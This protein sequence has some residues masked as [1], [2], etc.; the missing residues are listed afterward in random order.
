MSAEKTM[1]DLIKEE[2]LESIGIGKIGDIFGGKG[3]TKS[4]KIKD[5]LDGLKK[6]L[7]LLEKD[8]NGLCFVN[9]V[10]FDMK[11]GHRNDTDGYAKAMTECDRM[12]GKIVDNL[13]EDDLLIITADHGCDPATQSTD[14]SREYVPMLIYGKRLKKG[15]DLKTIEGFYNIGATILD[16]LE[17]CQ[18]DTLGK[19]VLKRLL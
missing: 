5:N 19:S 1:L 2:G 4:H 13:K 10:D 14:H 16:W 9:L 12:L 6:T 7:K 3:L 17:V 8:F 15:V 11:F 18:Q